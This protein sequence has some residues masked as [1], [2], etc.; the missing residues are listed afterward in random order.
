[1]TL[2]TLAALSLAGA[3]ATASGGF[4][5]TPQGQGPTAAPA[6][7]KLRDVLTTLSPRGRQIFVEDWLRVERKE[8]PQ[9]RLDVMTAQERA[10]AAMNAEPFNAEALRKA[11]AD[12]RAL[13]LDHQRS[14]QERLVSVL[15]RLSVEDRRQ[16]VQQLRA[17]RERQAAP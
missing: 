10:L 9:R 2:K 7:G 1:M 3:L 8:G 4:A 16:V 15:A 13:A 12:Q 11:Y 14:R 17:L 5:Q 6:G